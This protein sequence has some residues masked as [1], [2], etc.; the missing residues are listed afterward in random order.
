MK[1]WLL[2]SI[3]L[4]FGWCGV[5]WANPVH[6]IERGETMIGIAKQY[7]QDW[8]ALCELNDLMPHCQIKAGKQL[9]LLSANVTKAPAVQSGEI[10]YSI[11]GRAPLLD[12]GKELGKS[13]QRINEEAWIELDLPLADKNYLRKNIDKNGPRRGITAAEGLVRIPT[14]TRIEQ[15]TF[16]RD[17]K[18]VARGPVRTT[19]DE[20][21]IPRPVYAERFVLPS[22]RTVLWMW[23]CENWV[24]WPTPVTP[25]ITPPTPP[26]RTAS[27]P[28][29][30][31]P[32]VVTAPPK[33]GVPPT[34]TLPK[35][36]AQRC[37]LDPKLVFGQEHEPKDNGNVA[38][39]TF[40]TAALY[41]IKRDGDGYTG[42]GVGLQNS[43]WDVRVNFG[44]GRA[45]GQS[46]AFGPA[47]E[48]ISDKGWTAEG[49]L[50]FGHMH[51]AFNQAQYANKREIDFVGVS[52]AFNDYQRR[53]QG[54]KWMPETRIYASVG[55]PTSVRAT[56]S[57][58]GV[59]ADA[60]ELERH[61]VVAQAGIHLDIFDAKYATFWARV[62]LFSE[63]PFSQTANLR[64][65]LSDPLRVCGVGVGFD[66]DLLH[67]GEAPGYGWWCDGIKLVDVSREG[68]RL[69]QVS[70]G[71]TATFDN[72]TVMT[73]L[74]PDDEAPD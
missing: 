22:G 36:Q 32:P 70:D 11:I 42:W 49:K 40:V 14:G 28:T 20:N 64:L 53:L 67:G 37:L 43:W 47:V 71:K 21:K 27:A 63:L 3:A 15:V 54:K 56:A 5:A 41:C 60:S 68:Y 30:S 51:Q 17:G 52:V 50:L 2:I 45:H 13:R 6:D 73:P 23:E 59:P 57:N 7:K 12:C 48:R 24:T 58:F 72:G 4:I 34:V 31:A 1:K 38:H 69:D 62:G 29:P 9:K 8:K 25:T 55:V 65:G 44:S 33:E 39:S 26:A 35:P 46:L 66:F 10:P 19:W 61:S 18:V 74:E 16:C